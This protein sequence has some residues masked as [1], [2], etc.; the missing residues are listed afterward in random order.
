MTRRLALRP[1]SCALALAILA[2]AFGS[3]LPGETLLL[4]RGLPPA[5]PA[6]AAAS[7]LVK[8]RVGWSA[9]EGVFV[10]D[11]FTIGGLGEI[12]VIDRVRTWGFPSV[13]SAQRETLGDLFERITLYGGLESET[14]P[15]TPEAAAAECACHGPV[16]IANAELRRGSSVAEN[17]QVSLTPVTDADGSPYREEGRILGLWQVDFQNLRW[18]VPGGLNVQFGV[19]GLGRAASG[20]KNRPTWFSHGSTTNGKHQFRLFGT[21]GNPVVPVNG[22]LTKDESIGINVQVWGHL[23]ANVAIRPAGKSWQAVLLGSPTFDVTQVDQRTLR[24]GPKGAAPTESIVRDFN[25]DGHADLVLRLSAAESGV[26]PAQSTACLNG[27][28]MDGVAFEGCDS[29]S[30]PPDLPAGLRRQLP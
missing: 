30:K 10:T 27:R 11:H 5:N 15:A 29:L 23:T 6:S 21:A 20:R 26:Q 17:R 4:D 7:Q 16:P 28:R 12:W 24:F 13:P 3:R 25:G 22:S 8:L 14:P 9:E 19:F 18:S 2:P 1:A